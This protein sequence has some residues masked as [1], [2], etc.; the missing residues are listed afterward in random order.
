MMTAFN[1]GCSKT[2]SSPI[3]PLSGNYTLVSF[4][5]SISIVSSLASSFLVKISFKSDSL[6]GST[7]INGYSA[8]YSSSGNSI[9]VSGLLITDI[10]S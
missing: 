4:Q 5:D 6:V 1:F 8:L 10:A 9:K 7:S 3:L 2:N